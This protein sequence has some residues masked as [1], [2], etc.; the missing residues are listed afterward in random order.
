MWKTKLLEDN[1]ADYRQN[2]MYGKSHFRQTQKV[3]TI[4]EMM[5]K[6]DYIKIGNI[7]SSKTPIR[8]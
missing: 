6:F 8:E 7:R 5:N 2:L 1:M 4:K 3:L